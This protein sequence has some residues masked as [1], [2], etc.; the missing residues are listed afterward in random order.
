MWQVLFTKY[1]AVVD[2]KNNTNER[3][4]NLKMSLHANFSFKIYIEG[5]VVARVIHICGLMF[6]P[7]TK[8]LFMLR[9]V[10]ISVIF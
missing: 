2:V 5:Q 10:N 6:Q 9:L 8:L 1:F 4:V 7:V 3:S